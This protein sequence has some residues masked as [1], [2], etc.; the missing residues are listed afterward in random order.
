MPKDAVLPPSHWKAFAS[1]RRDPATKREA[2]L[3]TAAQLF[4][5]KSYGR[6]SLND[7]AERLNITKPALYHYFRNKE[8]ILLE[9][10]RLGTGLIEEILNEIADHCGTGLE[11][12]EAF[13]Y[14]YANVMTVNFGRCVMRLDQGDLSSEALGEVRTYKRKIDRRLRSFIQEGIGDGS[15][16]RCDPKIAAF[17]I[18]GAVNWICMWYE[19]D[20]ALSAEEIA[21]QFARTLTQGLVARRRSKPHAGT[22]PA[23]SPVPVAGGPL[24]APRKRQRVSNQ[25]SLA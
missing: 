22:M 13:I 19:P 8:D 7:V 9:C 6:T 20:G 2:V 21:S 15:I 25:E 3:E 1:R 17:S 24:P 11:K 18:A 4:L 16:T 5:E 12:V 10:Y 23:R 14:S